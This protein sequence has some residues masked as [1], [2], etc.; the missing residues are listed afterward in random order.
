MLLCDAEQRLAAGK[1]PITT[2]LY[3]GLKA[4]AATA[5]SKG[6]TPQPSSTLPHAPITSITP[7]AASISSTSPAVASFSPAVDS[8]SPAAVPGIST[9]TSTSALDSNGSQ[10]GSGQASVSHAERAEPSSSNSAS[11]NAIP[12]DITG[13]KQQTFEEDVQQQQQQ[14]QQALQAQQQLPRRRHLAT[15]LLHPPQVLSL[16]CSCNPSCSDKLSCSCNL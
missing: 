11:E 6:L 7:E 9:V 12:A 4:L 5:P 10:A 2:S 3:E 8:A 13:Q 14:E 16:P 15:K 1:L